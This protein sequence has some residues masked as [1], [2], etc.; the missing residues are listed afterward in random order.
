MG[1]AHTTSVHNGSGT[2]VL[3]TD[4]NSDSAFTQSAEVAPPEPLG[5]S[6][7]HALIDYMTQQMGVPQDYA[8]RMI[9][10]S[11]LP[12]EA[13]TMLK[14]FTGQMEMTPE[15]LR[16]QFGMNEEE[17]SLVLQGQDSLSLARNQ[18]GIYMTQHPFGAAFVQMMAMMYSLGVDIKQVM[19]EQ[20]KLQKS[21]SID[22]AEETFNGKIGVFA[23]AMLAGL[24]TAGG[25]IMNAVNTRNRQPAVTK[26]G[27]PNSPLAKTEQS[28]KELLDSN[29]SENPNTANNR[30]VR[31]EEDAT[32]AAT[33]NSWTSP[34]GL[35]LI[36]QPIN[37][38]GG[39]IDAN[40]ELKAAKKNAEVEEARGI[41]Q[42]L[43]SH[44][45]G[46]QTQMNGAAAGI[47]GN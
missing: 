28:K 29:D 15:M 41:F 6:D 19:L 14:L 24:I 21:K 43:T 2:T 44:Q 26:D 10:K 16:Q 17:A 5:N 39:F 4:G 8:E 12:D 9:D 27:Q 46:I 36:T 42:L 25:G 33:N 30:N 40:Y 22:A 31:A 35:S 38:A 20:I 34:V 37:A 47:A 18:H 45:Q 32:N 7:R 1:Q 13:R 23:A 11:L 3:T